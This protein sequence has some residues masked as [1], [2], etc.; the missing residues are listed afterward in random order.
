MAT[1]YFAAHFVRLLFEGGYYSRVVFIFL[2][3]LETST[4]VGTSEMVTTARRCQLYAQPLSPAV[5][6]GNDSYNTNSPSASVV[7][8]VRNLSYMYTCVCAMFSSRGYY[9]RAAFTAFRSSGLCSYY[10]RVA[11]IRG[12]CLFEEMR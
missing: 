6:C 5:S 3:S 1:I 7:T 8:I 4:M 9:S 10:L 2:E 12:W 11:T